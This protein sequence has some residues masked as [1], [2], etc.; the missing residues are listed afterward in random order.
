MKRIQ[1]MIDIGNNERWGLAFTTLSRVK[2][3][4]ELCLQPIFPF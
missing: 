2:T 4:D 3:L 1:A